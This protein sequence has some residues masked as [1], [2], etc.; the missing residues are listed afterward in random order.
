[1]E[2]E[3]VVNNPTNTLQSKQSTCSDI[4]EIS[5]MTEDETNHFQTVVSFIKR[6]LVA[7]DLKWSL[8]VAASQSYKHDSCLRPY[9]PMFVK[10]G[11]KDFGGL[12]NA[13]ESIP[14]FHHLESSILAKPA[15]LLLY[16]VLLELKEPSLST[17]N[18]SEVDEVLQLVSCELA[19]PRPSLVVRLSYEGSASE[20]RWQKEE[21]RHG[22]LYAFHGSR[23]DNFHSILHHG[24][25]QHLT[26]NALFG[27]GVYF[28]SELLVC[29]PYSR[30]G[31]LWK[32]SCLGS[33]CSV[34]AMCQ[35]IDH[36]TILCQNEQA[37]E[38]NKSRARAQDSLAGE[39]PHKLYVVPNSDLI[40]V[41]Y[42]LV[43]TE[44]SNSSP[45]QR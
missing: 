19:P 22:S 39:V 12:M 21:E 45:S 31:L 42:L 37:S 26:K 6:D 44:K 27:Q 33:A 4:T 23:V 38:E 14:A 9:P 24:L 3:A 32:H 35:I 34:V 16:W 25:Q 15:V 7:A 10:D 41:R 30:T 8:F 18:Q 43:Y 2:D 13:I 28:S 29:L 36:P 5:S 1:M 20:R 11:N 40:Q 17:V